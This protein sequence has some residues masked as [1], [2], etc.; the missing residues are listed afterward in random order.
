[1]IDNGSSANIISKEVLA[2]MNLGQITFQKVA[3]PLVGFGGSGIVP[4][5]TLALS[6]SLGR[7]PHRTVKLI[8]FLVVETPFAYNAILG[9]PALNLFRAVVSTYH[10]KIKFPTD[11]GIGEIINDH[12]MAW[13][14]YNTSLTLGNRSRSITPAKRKL[15]DDK[16]IQQKQP[17]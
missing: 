3:T 7:K 8:K 12:C 11:M 4:C 16:R 1:L 5:G 2:Q 15:E 14:C 17:E 9:R 6:V 10:Q 13:D